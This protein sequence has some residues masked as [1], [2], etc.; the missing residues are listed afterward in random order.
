MPLSGLRIIEFSGL[1]PAPLAGQLLSDLGADVIAVD[2]RIGPSDPTDVN[3]RGK[4]SIVLDLK[5]AKGRAAAHRL[6]EKADVVIEGFRPGVMEGLGLGPQDAPEHL[7]YGRMT[8][9]GQ[10][11]PWAA[12]AG[13]DLNYL[14]L[15]G[16]LPMFGTPGQP[17]HPALNY[18]ADYG[19]GTMFLIMGILSA[20]YERSRSGKGQVVDAAMVDGVA[21]MAGLIYSLMAQAMSGQQRG[22]NFLDGSAPYYRCYACSDGRYMA[23][24]C[25]EPKFF[26]EF[27]EI[28]DLP[29][30]HAQQ[31][32][33]RQKWPEMHADYEARFQQKTRDEWAELFAGS[34]ACVT[35]VLTLSEAPGHPHMAA[36]GTLQQVDG[37]VH[38]TPAPRFGRSAVRSPAPPGG[39]GADTAEVLREAGLSDAEIADLA[40]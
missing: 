8:G 23:V 20:L 15:T 30:E 11:G 2:R 27:L 21:A 22:Q 19:G 3:R 12:T 24:G 5:S 25:L 7:I 6:L 28:A 29:R 36:R 10:D 35:P 9:W 33:D 18:V 38:P 4:R 37:T 39:I 1:G 31:Q 34:D 14:S 32:N 40:S 13:H 16:M 17:P 26:A